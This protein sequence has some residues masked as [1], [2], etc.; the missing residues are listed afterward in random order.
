[1]EVVKSDYTSDEV[2][3]VTL[4]LLEKAGKVSVLC[5]KDVPG[6]IGNRMQHA[7]AREAMSL[8]QNG[9]ASAE[10][11]D[12][13]VKTSLAIRLVFTGPLEQRDLNGLDTHIS[14]NEYLY[15]SLEDA[16]QPLEILRAKVAAGQFGLKTGQGFYDWEG[17]TSL[18][19]NEEKNLALI[20][21]LKYLGLDGN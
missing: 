21:L 15:P 9:V 17:K 16:K 20:N 1:V 14:V 10:D 5:K 2:A 3:Q 8:A 4:K 13:V 6:F 7:L 18:E 12:T 11:I 19:V